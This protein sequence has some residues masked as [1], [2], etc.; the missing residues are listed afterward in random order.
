MLKRDYYQLAGLAG[1]RIALCTESSATKNLVE[2]AYVKAIVAGDEMPV[3]MIYKDPFML[4]P[5]VKLWWS[6]NALPAVADTSEGFWRRMCVIP[7]NREFK[8]NERIL[9]LNERLE[10]ELPGIFN[11]AMDGLRRLHDRGRFVEPA[12]VRTQTDQYRKESNPVA[13]FVE[14]ECYIEEDPH[15]QTQSSQIYEAYSDFCKRC[16]YKPLSIKNFKHELER[17]G[18][19][20][21][22][23]SAGVYYGVALKI[24]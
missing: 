4:E 1:R 3:R 2:D 16:G 5:R 18:H 23:R 6:M 9:D 19:Y 10:T 11:W 21:V 12:Q 22:R 15:G 24:P 8:K 17:L 14:E 13:Q 7:F 20:A